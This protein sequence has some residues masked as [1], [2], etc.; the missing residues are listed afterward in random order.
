[1]LSKKGYLIHLTHL[2]FAGLLYSICVIF[3]H[4]C[5]KYQPFDLSFQFQRC[6]SSSYLNKTPINWLSHIHFIDFFS[7]FAFITSSNEQK[8]QSYIKNDYP[9]DIKKPFQSILWIYFVYHVIHLLV[10]HYNLRRSLNKQN[11]YA[12]LYRQDQRKRK[13]IK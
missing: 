4:L 6:Q 7:S 13:L 9:I 1:M 11:Y 3:S 2:V 5:N 10:F 12:R 8:C